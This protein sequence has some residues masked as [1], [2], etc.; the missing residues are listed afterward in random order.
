[1]EYGISH[2]STTVARDEVNH[3]WKGGGVLKLT[4][5]QPFAIEQGWDSFQRHA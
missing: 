1:M 5:H 3:N 2:K 4:L